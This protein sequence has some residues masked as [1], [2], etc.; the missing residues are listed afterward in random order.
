[1]RTTA[2]RI[3]HAISFEVIGLLIFMPLMAWGFDYPV[4]DFGVLGVACAL[5]AVVWNYFYNIAFDK[6]ML[7]RLGHARKSVL[8]RV[9]HA[10]L[11][12]AGLLALMLP[13]IAWYLSIGLAEAF[14]M[15]VAFSAFYLVYAYV[16]NWA[17]D[18]VFPP[19]SP[20]ESGKAARNFRSPA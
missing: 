19:P 20:D 17:Y 2:D 18:A 14:R 6:V 10:C 8:V 5:F 7:R 11:F 15:D 1:M 9:L 4:G 16:F 3:R 12:E 13:F